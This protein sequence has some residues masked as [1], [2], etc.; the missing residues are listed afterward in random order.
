[1]RNPPDRKKWKRG[2]IIL[3]DDDGT[4]FH[5]WT[6][7]GPRHT[8]P[9][10]FCRLSRQTLLEQ[11]LDRVARLAPPRATAIVVN[12]AHHEFYDGLVDVPRSC[13][14][15]QPSNRGTVPAILCGLRRL[16]NLGRNTIVAVFPCDHRLRSDDRLI[17]HLEEA[18]AAVEA[19]PSLLVL[20]GMVPT[21]AK[22]SFGWIEPGERV[23]PLV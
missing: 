10:Q 9:K 20:L 3:A 2:V 8:V 17:H 22:N 16:A 15:A 1:M 19:C 7:S 5:E 11:T 13:I 6:E 12:R 21:A 14:V 23:Y 4:H 18:M